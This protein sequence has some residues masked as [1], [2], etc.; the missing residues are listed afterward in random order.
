MSPVSVA[1]KFFCEYILSLVCELMKRQ[2]YT[3]EDVSEITGYHVSNLTR[4]FEGK[5]Y[6]LVVTA[7]VFYCV[8]N[9]CYLDGTDFIPF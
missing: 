4:L 2:S 1:K 8:H 9:Q 5:Y 3:I 6:S 7:V